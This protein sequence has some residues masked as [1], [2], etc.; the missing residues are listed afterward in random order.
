MEDADVEDVVRE[1]LFPLLSAHARTRTPL[2]LA[3]T[4]AFLER[5]PSLSPK[6]IELLK[7]LVQDKLVEIAATFFHEVYPHFLKAKYLSAQIARDI[8]LKQALLGVQPTCFYPANFAWSPILPYIMSSL[9]LSRIILDQAHLDVVGAMQDWKWNA[10]GQMNALV[11]AALP[12]ESI[13]RMW[14]LFDNETPILDLFFVDRERVQAFSFGDVGKIHNPQF[15][16]LTDNEPSILEGP[17]GLTIIADD[18][19]RI[20]ALSA[21]RYEQELSRARKFLVNMNEI[22]DNAPG[23]LDYLPGFSLGDTFDF[24]LSGPESLHWLS[25]LNEV[26]NRSG[27]VVSEQLLSLQD[28][29]PI[30]WR[31]HW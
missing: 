25:I 3:I 21:L 1:S 20:N 10:L 7:Q 13:R 27:G 30:F 5:L 22:S 12:K 28:V 14:I 15:E 26:E 6:T 24:W 4:G 17:P 29:Y 16:E 9:G 18:G 19:D 11:P 8:E 2:T 23:R 31:T